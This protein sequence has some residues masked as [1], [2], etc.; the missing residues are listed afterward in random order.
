[1]TAA[2]RT[3]SARRGG[4]GPRS[5]VAPG[6]KPV[7]YLVGMVLMA[8]AGMML[9]P[10]LVDIYYWNR[11]WLSFAAASLLSGVIGYGL[12]YT[13]RKSLKAGLTLR[14]AFLLTPLSWFSVAAVSAM[15][16]FFS[17]FGIVSGSLSNAFF[18]SVSGITTTGATVL[19]D[20]E[21]APPGM[22][23]WRALLQWM[24]GIG[25]IATAIA[26]LPALGIG[27]MQ[28][29]RTESS[30]R[31][32]KAMPRVRQIALMIA[33]VYLGLTVLAAL[34]YWIAGMRLFDAV[35]H[36][37]TSI[38]TGGYSTSDESFGAWSQNGIQWFAALFMLCGAIPFVLYVRVIAGESRALWDRQVKT[39][40][41][42][43]GVVV[44]LL[45][46]WLILSGQ[47]GVEPAFRHAAFNVISV[48]TTTGYASANYS[49]WGNAAIGL[50]F[51]LMF[52]G[53]CTGSTSGGIKIFR[54]EV[55]AVMLKAHFLRLIYPRGVFPRSYGERP[56]NDE[57]VGSVVAFF[58][59][60]FLCYAVLTIALMALGID[61]LTSASGAVSALSNVGPG[62]GEII[63][64]AG[65]FAPLPDAAKWLL[66][67][68]MLLGRLELFTVLVLFIPRF[69]RG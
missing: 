9:F 45:A 60:F 58:A 42:I 30:D 23:L 43:I 39:M 26:I 3:K 1:M 51:G 40:L 16:F 25:I 2:R 4:A 22:L 11:D 49:A 18:E 53:G 69:W 38:S 59:V 15:P 64:P 7:L 29:F 20:L 66:S 37:L 47:Y 62:L 36:A 48:V 54:Y 41:A 5:H 57:V 34:V 68:G 52:I 65:N 67:F 63:G 50:F 19:S 31:S 24:G 35:A 55:L 13:S 28:L 21:S 17:D 46:L 27:G 10:M 56:L 8:T 14:Q 44:L 6:I 33:L 32:E 61:F 12:V